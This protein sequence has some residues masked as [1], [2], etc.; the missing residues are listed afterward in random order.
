MSELF[1]P[2]VEMRQLSDKTEAGQIREREIM[3]AVKDKLNQELLSV[4]K[5]IGLRNR[6]NAMR[7]KYKNCSTSTPISPKT[8]PSGSAT[9]SGTCWR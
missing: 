9:S 3:A 8:S 4:S 5:E 1:R 2:K 7:Q 6:L